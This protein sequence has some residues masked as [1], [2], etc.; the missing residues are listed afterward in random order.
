MQTNLYS[1]TVPLFAKH[2][3]N[4]GTLLEKA[5]AHAG[6]DQ[7]ELVRLMNESLAEDMYPLGR[8]IEMATD[9]AKGAA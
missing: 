8:Q 4:L 5:E 6:D 9:N 1:V 3:L 7:N 2:L